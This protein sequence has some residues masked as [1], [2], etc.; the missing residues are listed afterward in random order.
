MF[1]RIDD[2]RGK[3]YE[4]CQSTVLGL[5]GIL[6]CWMRQSERLEAFKTFQTPVN[7]LHSKFNLHT[8]AEI[9]TVEDY[10]HL[11]VSCSTEV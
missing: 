3:S 9:V 4:L 8:G 10:N 7:A 6:A 5:R 1:R 2:D 11:Q